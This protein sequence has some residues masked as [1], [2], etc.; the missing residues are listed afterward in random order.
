MVIPVSEKKSPLARLVLFMV[1]LSIAGVLV[2]GAYVSLIEQPH[3]QSLTAPE[4]GNGV[5]TACLASCDAKYWRGTTEGVVKC[6]ECYNA[7]TRQY[8][9]G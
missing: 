1:C 6:A 5:L 9:Y 7:C 2:S 8:L 3:R 4:N